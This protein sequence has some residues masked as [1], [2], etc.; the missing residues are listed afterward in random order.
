MLSTVL[1]TVVTVVVKVVVVV[2]VG[3]V[4]DSTSDVVLAGYKR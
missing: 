1:V 4:P 2:D 3:Q